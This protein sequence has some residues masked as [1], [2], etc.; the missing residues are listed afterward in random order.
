MEF[1]MIHILM[2]LMA[3][4]LLFAILNQRHD[5][6]I[7]VAN[8]T[9]RISGRLPA[10]ARGEIESFFTRDLAHLRRF[11]VSGRRLSGGGL[12]LT[13]RGRMSAGDRQRIRNFFHSGGW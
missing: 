11:R 9:V 3:A 2:L 10:V 4:A 6:T 12:R 1:G 5:F 13:I 7:R 8:G